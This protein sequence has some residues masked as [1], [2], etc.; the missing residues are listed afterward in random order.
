MNLIHQLKENGITEFAII[1]TEKLTSYP[2]VYHLRE[3]KG[4]LTGLEPSFYDADKF[5]DYIKPWQ[6]IIGMAIPYGLL[7]KNR[8]PRE[9]QISSVSIMAWEWDY[10]KKIRN[11]MDQILGQSF[12][13]QLHVDQGPLP[14]RHLALVMGLAEAGRSQLLIHTEYGTAFHLAFILTNLEDSSEKFG[15][16]GVAVS[17]YKL[18]S[19]CINCRQCQWHCPTK[20]L[21]GESD[22]DGSHCI[23]AITQKKGLLTDWEMKAMGRQLY[24]CDL[25]QLSCPV[26]SPLNCTMDNILLD[27][28]SINRLDPLVILNAS[29][30]TFV[31]DFGEMGFSWRGLGVIKRN[32]LTN[33]G[34][35]GH[36]NHL[37]VLNDLVRN[38]ETTQ[39]D[40]LAKTAHWAIHQIKERH[41]RKGT[42]HEGLKSIIGD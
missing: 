29:Q 6:H 14:E 42:A 7:P 39:N 21:T 31:K 25:C 12:D 38:Y 28:E 32:A 13:Y 41:Q 27:R 37:E 5:L 40:I 8:M 22:F 10:H 33:L 36:T 11:L 19:K 23:S 26:N 3:G 4:Q 20:A 35:Y 24:G 34:N 16:T 9:E 1:E 30:K 18:S 17:G 15:G 2:E